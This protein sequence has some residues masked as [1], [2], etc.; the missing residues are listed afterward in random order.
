MKHRK[1]LFSEDLRAMFEM[2]GR[3]PGPFRAVAS[4]EAP[5]PPR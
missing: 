4:S 2:T 1:G 5:R 3:D